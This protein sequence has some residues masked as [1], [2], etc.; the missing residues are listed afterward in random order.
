VEK[1]LKI[2]KKGTTNAKSI[3]DIKGIPNGFPCRIA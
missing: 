3:Y 1:I 2:K